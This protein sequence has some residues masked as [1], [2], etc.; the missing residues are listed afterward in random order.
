MSS[1][2]IDP[3]ALA[4]IGIDHLVIAT[5]EMAA[6]VDELERTLGVRPTFGG[7]HTGGGTY[8]HLLHLGGETYLEVIAP[9]PEQRI[10]AGRRLPF[11]LDEDRPA[12]LAGFAIRTSDLAGVVSR[13]RAAG[14]DPGDVIDME[15]R[16]P[17]GVTLRWQLAVPPSGSRGGLVP[18]VID[19]LD[20]PHPS[21]TTPR[22]C[23]LVGLRVE[24][25]EPELVGRDLAALAVDLPVDLG[26]AP[27]L[28]ATIDGP[29]GR[30][31]LR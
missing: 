8:N 29:T 28:V 1:S 13:A 30:V 21:A 3:A 17:D 11:G 16:R 14:Y 7:Q 25:P 6:T 20:S 12:H 27:A 9:D 4:R 22:G 31:E 24:H 2:P 10:P 5:R 15:R 19:W 23:T 18:F 26:P